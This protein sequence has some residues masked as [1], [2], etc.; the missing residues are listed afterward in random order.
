[1]ST[2]KKLPL[3]VAV[4]TALGVGAAYAGEADKYGR[5]SH[6]DIDIDKT[7]DVD[8]N[9]SYN[10]QIYTLG[11][12]LVDSSAAAFSEVV[13][14]THD[15]KL[16]D[17]VIDPETGA[18]LSTPGSLN[19][20]NNATL[21]G[22][23]LSD[24][25]GNAGVNVA[26]GS[27]NVQQNSVAIAEGDSLNS[28]QTIEIDFSNSYDYVDNDSGSWTKSAYLH[29]DA[30]ESSSQSA[31]ATASSSSAANL[32]VDLDVDDAI[33]VTTP[34]GNYSVSSV[35][36]GVAVGEF[37]ADIG[38]D[39]GEGEDLN[40]VSAEGEF[41]AGGLLGIEDGTID[42]GVSGQDAQSASASASHSESA[43]IEGGFDYAEEGEW[44]YVNEEHYAF[45][46]SFDINLLFGGAAEAETFSDQYSYN[47]ENPSS[48]TNDA[49][50]GDS[51]GS[52]FSG[53]IGVNVVAGNNNAQ[54]NQLALAENSGVMALATASSNQSVHDNLSVGQ[55]STEDA[56]MEVT[57]TGSATGKYEGI[58]DQ[59]GDVYLD[60]WSGQQHSSGSNTG[61]VDVDSEAQG[62]QDD[63]KDGGAFVFTELGTI[64]L[65]DI[66]LTGSLPVVNVVPNAVVN[67]ATLAGD[68]FSDASGNIA[69]NVAAGNGNLQGNA[70]A[71]AS[72]STPAVGGGGGG[73]GGE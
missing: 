61:H 46:A 16:T 34:D 13:Q 15:N 56:S 40:A 63:L 50:V 31:S 60:T 62:A 73:G 45:S 38:G 12:V 68:A 49:W 21:A 48:G 28:T 24:A 9:L 35:V 14:K 5:S 54:A 27:N 51:V 67:N 65:G 33:T 42:Y 41:V 23:V 6:S 25:T 39:L 7:V 11:L 58:A 64:D 17:L 1:M 69:I 29:A 26:A 53:N 52:G 20:D 47:N 22:N 8:Y 44:E 43:S 72:I 59:R 37:D 70:L 4:A 2:F 10:G 18:V 19:D 57:L 32:D 71:I 30:S 36:G 3:A 66:E 55:G